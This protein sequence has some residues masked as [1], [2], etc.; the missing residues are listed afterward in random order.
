M[1][2]LIVGNTGSGK[3]T[4]ANELK[5]KTNG[6][7]F[8]IDTW[9]NTLFIADKKPEDGLEWFLERIDRAEVLIMNLVQQ[10][11]ASKIDA[12][13]DLGLSKFQHR[14]KFRKFAETNGYQHKTHFLDVS[15]ETRLNRVMKRNAEK[16]DTFEFEVSKE[17]FD[18]M[19]TWFQKPGKEEM[20][21]GIVSSE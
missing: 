10:L 9:N 6:I 16:G 14:E 12:I 8:S 17:N 2:H 11:E 15:K 7:I 3:T 13:L 4:Y 1:I 18:F 19:E 21:N 5:R 20:K